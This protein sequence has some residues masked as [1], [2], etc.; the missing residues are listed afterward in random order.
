MGTSAA[1]AVL[2][3]VYRYVCI[4]QNKRRDAAGTIEGFDHAYEDDVTDG[5]V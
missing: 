4:Y 1:S 3:L 5:K 2:A